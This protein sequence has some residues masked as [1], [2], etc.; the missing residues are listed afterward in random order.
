[1]ASTMMDVFD[2]NFQRAK[3]TGTMIAYYIVCKR[4]LWLFANHIT[5][6]K[7]S[8]LVDIGRLI[9][10]T[11]FKREKDK[12]IMIGDTLKVDFL[13]LGDSIVVHEVKK[14]RKLED[15]HIWQVKFYV[16]YLKNLG[17][18]CSSGVIHYPKLMRKID[19]NFTEDDKHKIENFHLEIN[20]LLNMKI[21]QPIKRGYCKNCAY[22]TFCYL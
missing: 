1:M 21:P 14:S 22:Y 19:V 7:Y 6:E 5:M 17:I 11:T 8:D 18:N 10:E 4:K 12:E 2:D 20:S 16:Y 9:S 3:I 13:K 15:A